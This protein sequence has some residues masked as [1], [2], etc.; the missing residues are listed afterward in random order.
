[1]P[2]HRVDLNLKGMSHFVDDQFVD[3]TGF[4][5]WEKDLPDGLHLERRAGRPA[6]KDRKFV[7]KPG[8]GR[9]IEWNSNRV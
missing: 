5:L 6:N 9:S 7:R 4:P 1:M 8:F 2:K 3:A